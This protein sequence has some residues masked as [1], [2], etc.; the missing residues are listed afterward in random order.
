M[1]CG[2]CDVLAYYMHAHGVRSIMLAVLCSAET[3]CQKKT[4]CPAEKKTWCPAVWAPSLLKLSR[5]VLLESERTV[6]SK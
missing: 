1:A 6:Q 5:R 4:W 2:S 3:W